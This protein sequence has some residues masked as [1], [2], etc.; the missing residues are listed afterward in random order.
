MSWKG[1]LTGVLDDDRGPHEQA[2]RVAAI[3]GGKIRGYACRTASPTT[4]IPRDDLINGTNITSCPFSKIRLH[5]S[6]ALPVPITDPKIQLKSTGSSG[7]VSLM[8]E[9]SN[10]GI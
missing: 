3:H 7:M 9:G 4:N 6:E 2:V 1:V 5:H 8:S 10:L